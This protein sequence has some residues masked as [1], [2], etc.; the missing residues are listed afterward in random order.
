MQGNNDNQNQDNS[1][2]EDFEGDIY[3][4]ELH[5]RLTAMKNERKKAELEAH[6]LESR[7]RLLKGEENKTLKKIEITKKKTEEKITTMEKKEENLRIKLE[8]KELK[9]KDLNEKKAITNK[10]KTEISE[11]TQTKRFVKMRQIEDEAKILKEQKKLNEELLYFIKLEEIAHNKSKADFIKNQHKM[12]EEKR[13]AIELERKNKIKLELEKK[14][15][16]EQMM[17]EE[18]SSKIVELE[19]E[20]VEIMRKIRTTTQIHKA[21]KFN[22]NYLV[23]E[24][25]EKMNMNNKDQYL[26]S[27]ASPIKKLS[28]KSI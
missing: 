19:Q 13:R 10:I 9:E 12:L 17:R 16:D 4:V 26:N 18:I 11:N 2:E 25:F 1:P 24:D 5:K 3:L 20:E 22:Y 27:T 8:I 23:V 15:N 28:N 21:C 7:L 6:T 14:I